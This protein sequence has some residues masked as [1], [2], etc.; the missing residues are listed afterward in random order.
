MYY[1]IYQ[2]TNLINEKF[3]VGIHKTDDL[4]DEY[5]GSGKL[6]VQAIKK[7][8]KENFKKEILWLCD[9]YQ[10]LKDFEK[11]I[12]NSNFLKQNGNKCYNLL[13]GGQGTT[14]FAGDR[15]SQYG[16]YWITK[17]TENKK[18]KK[19]LLNSYLQ[20]G[21][22]KGRY[23]IINKTPV[24]KVKEKISKSLIKYFNKNEHHNKNKIRVHKDNKEKLIQK[25][26]LNKYKQNGWIEGRNYKCIHFKHSEKTKNDMKLDKKDR[27]YFHKNGIVKMVKKEEI[28]K[29]LQ[30]GWK[31]GRGSNYKFMET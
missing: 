29:Y 22:I 6:I 27:R 24:K 3:Y 15:N 20:L 21:W 5:L 12:V 31:K 30:E 9:N 14:I 11:E 18:I 7:Y 8:G 28:E 13:V 16:T 10:E 25:V 2:T 1:I 17:G 23:G 26:E 4:K 19:E